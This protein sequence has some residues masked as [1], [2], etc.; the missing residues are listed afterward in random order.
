[1]REREEPAEAI[2]FMQQSS[3]QSGSP[4]MAPGWQGY[5]HAITLS[6]VIGGW[7]EQYSASQCATNRSVSCSWMRILCTALEVRTRATIFAVSLRGVPNSLSQGLKADLPGRRS[8]Q[9][10]SCPVLGRPQ[11]HMHAAW[12]AQV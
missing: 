10:D 5:C 4:N 2:S 1:M 11:S 8:L 12:H 9:A 7:E 6:P 3:R